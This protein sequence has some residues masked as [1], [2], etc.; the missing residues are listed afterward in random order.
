MNHKRKDR[1]IE[2]GKKV[3]RNRP[4]A[5]DLII[6]VRIPHRIVLWIGFM[7]VWISFELLCDMIQNK[8]VVPLER[9][10]SKKEN[11]KEGRLLLDCVKVG[12]LG[13]GK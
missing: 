3:F 8:K 4:I 13:W 6:I 11:N 10:E 9:K 1:R 5:A 7:F 12:C 2:D